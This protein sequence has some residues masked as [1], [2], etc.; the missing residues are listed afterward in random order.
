MY[1]RLGGLAVVLALLGLWLAPEASPQAARDA[2]KTTL[3]ISRALDGGYPNGPSRGAVIS[4]DL[5]TASA[6]AFESDASNL[7]RGDVNHRRDVFVVRRAAPFTKDGSLWNR[8]STELASRG[9]G[10]VP[11]NGSS[12][13]AAI[14]GDPASPPRCVA[15]VSSASNLVQGDTN[16]KPDAFVYNLVNRRVYRVSVDS[17]GRQAN[18]STYDVAIDGNCSHV[19]FT[20][21]APRLAFRKLSR[22]QLQSLKKSKRKLLAPLGTDLPKPGVREVYMRTINPHDK[23]FGLTFLVS[24][25]NGGEPADGDSF[26]PAFSER[27]GRTNRRIA[28]TSTARNLVASDHGRTADVYLRD[29]QGRGTPFKTYLISATRSGKPGDG[30]SYDPAPSEKGQYVSYETQASNLLPGDAD[31]IA[32]IGRADIRTDPIKQLLASPDTSAPASRPATSNGGVYVLWDTPASPA[33]SVQLFTATRKLRKEMSVR[34]DGS[35]VKLPAFNPSVSA[36]GNYVLFET[37]DP[38]ADLAFIHARYPQFAQ[39]EGPA[40]ATAA[41]GPAF[42]QVY[43]RYLG[44]R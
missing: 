43:M 5:R 36:R 6:I 44:P 37:A 2:V 12:Y 10:G 24:A 29:M 13:G 4:H 39:D 41:R 9:L 7:V 25:S 14:D 33:R 38:F 8:G 27:W 34:S 30:P 1:P 32:D 28:F 3:L 26:D 20:S 18:G 19:A 40:L 17:F 22:T 42:Y 31:H 11:A 21:D 16:G 23:R 35:S 15:F